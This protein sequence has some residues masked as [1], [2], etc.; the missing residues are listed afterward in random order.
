MR[1]GLGVNFSTDSLEQTSS[2][3]GGRSRF[4]TD[5]AMRDFQISVSFFLFLPVF[6]PWCFY[7]PTINFFYLLQPLTTLQG[8]DICL[9]GLNLSLQ[10]KGVSSTVT[11]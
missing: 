9:R 4:N 7:C 5:D 8:G 11:N 10:T 2:L 1:K 3:G 6:I